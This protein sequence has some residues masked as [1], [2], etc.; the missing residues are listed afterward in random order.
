MEGEAFFCSNPLCPAVRLR[1]LIHFVSKKGINIEF[2]GPKLLEK[3]YNNQLVVTF[4][5][6]YLLDQEKILP[7]EGM[8]EK[9]CSQLIHH[10]EKSKTNT[11]L[12]RFIYALGI[13][14]IG[15]QNAKQISLHFSQKSS[16]L[17]SLP[18]AGPA[19][20]NEKP[21]AGRTKNSAPK[22]PLPKQKTQPAPSLL[23]ADFSSWPKP[24]VLL[25]TASFE[26]LNTIPDLGDISARYI[27]QAFSNKQ[28]IRDLTKLFRLGFKIKSEK[29]P[30]HKEKLPL[31]GM[32]FV[33]TGALPLPREQIKK[34]IIHAGG[35]VQNTVTKKTHFL[36]SPVEHS[37]ENK[38]SKKS[39]A[40][41]KMGVKILNWE[42]FQNLLSQK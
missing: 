17:K 34:D 7:L 1:S 39:L 4:V 37:D 23:K 11:P 12:S 3:L 20:C 16:S 36:L 33:I 41:K 10:I 42:S 26:E 32:Q 30:A 5:D 9:S 25:A 35:T 28:L 24:L 38:M 19:G 21:S 18:L 27:I 2:L 13:R 6:L 31:T 40:A 8:G 29:L 15:E 14:H 22:T